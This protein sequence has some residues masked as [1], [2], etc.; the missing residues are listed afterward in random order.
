MASREATKSKR[1]PVQYTRPTVYTSSIKP[2]VTR[3]WVETDT[4][5]TAFKV[6]TRSEKLLIIQETLPCDCSTFPKLVLSSRLLES[7]VSL[8][9]CYATE[10]LLN[11]ALCIHEL[12]QIQSFHTFACCPTLSLLSRC[13]VPTVPSRELMYYFDLFPLSAFSPVTVPFLGLL[14]CLQLVNRLLGV[15]KK[16]FS[17]E[18]IKQIEFSVG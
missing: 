18:I 4:R 7:P 15:L 16:A 13:H 12:L 5:D 3:E 9:T 6:F 1:T 11:L 10:G 8:G 2:C 17:A 14:C